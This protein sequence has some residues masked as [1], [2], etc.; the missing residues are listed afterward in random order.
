MIQIHMVKKRVG[1]IRDHV[2]NIN[3]Q[4]GNMD[5][6]I[7]DMFR[8]LHNMVPHISKTLRTSDSQRSKTTMEGT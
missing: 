6:H 1:S 7:M 4:L 3:E 8:S 2:G 5:A